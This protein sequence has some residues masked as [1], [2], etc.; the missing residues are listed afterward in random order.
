M[1]K[2][3]ECLCPL[4]VD[5]KNTYFRVF[6]GCCFMVMQVKFLLAECLKAIQNEEVELFVAL[7]HCLIECFLC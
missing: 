4:R 5:N 7:S 3:R 1:A 6:F 2:S